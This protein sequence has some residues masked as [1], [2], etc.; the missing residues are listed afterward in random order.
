MK[1]SQGTLPHVTSATEAEDAA[2]CLPRHS[3]SPTRV[4]D[5]RTFK[6]LIWIGEP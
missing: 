5:C 1:S 2:V 6:H 4:E 3:S